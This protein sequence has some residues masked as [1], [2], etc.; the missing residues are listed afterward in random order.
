MTD[1]DKQRPVAIVTGASSGIGMA[2]A[3]KLAL[4]GA[5]VTVNYHS[6][7]EPA[8][9]LAAEICGQGGEAVAVGADVSR[10]DGVRHLFDATV[11][12]FGRVD[13]LVANSG[14]QQDA[15]IADMTLE[16][17]RAV[18]DLDLTGQF[19]CAR[20]AVRRFRAQDGDTA[21]F[22]AR[23]AIVS[24][25][26]V[27]DRIPWAGHINYAA[28]KS[29]ARMLVETLAQEVAQDGIRVNAVAPGAIRTPINED[30]W[31]NEESFKKLLELIPYGRIGEP[32]DVAEAVAWLVSDAADYVTGTTL[33][34][35][36]GMMLYP[37]F[38]GNG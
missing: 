35:D 8:E 34:V 10:E 11:E 32:G 28:A 29:G 15:P 20:E 14:A 7:R 23:G 19:L 33:Y 38:R 16:Q 26:S 36:G 22:R 27:H 6:H 9:A 30:V 17:W 2:V 4:D 3:R 25:T 31:S 1:S 21:P 18:I 12:T 24:M 13:I 5:A 37:G